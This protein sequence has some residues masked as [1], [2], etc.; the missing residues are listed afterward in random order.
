MI[1]IGIDPGSS[2]GA[3]AKVFSDDETVPYV[4]DMLQL[5]KATQRDIYDFL[6]ED[7]EDTHSALLEKVNAMPGQGVSSTF[8]FG[9]SF[10]ELR[11]ALVATHI[12]FELVTPAKW[13]REMGCLSGGDKKITRR[14]AQELF[15]AEKIPH[16][17]ADAILLAELARRRTVR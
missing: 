17:K 13:Q 8:K 3:I 1:H 12:P 11:M 16:W 15:P 4:A 6:R 5:S 10:G 2:S 9:C 14:R 7:T